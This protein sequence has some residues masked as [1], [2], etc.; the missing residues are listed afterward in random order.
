MV[1]LAKAGSRVI[2]VVTA[3]IVALLILYGGYSIWDTYSMSRNAFISNDLLRFKP[4]PGDIPANESLGDLMQI[5][6]DV[7]GW[8]TIDDTHIDYP[9][10]QGKDDME[11]VNKDVYGEYSLSGSIFLSSMNSPDFSDTYNVVFGHHMDNGAMFGDIYNFMSED[12]F[13]SHK[14][15][16]LY[17]RGATYHISV[18]ALLDTD[19]YDMIYNIEGINDSG[20]SELI[21]HLSEKSICYRDIGL[22]STDKILAMSTCY[23][24]TTS[25]RTILFGRLE[26]IGFS[27]HGVK[28]NEAT[29]E[30]KEVQPR[31]KSGVD[32]KI[33]T[34]V[35]A[36][37][38]LGVLVLIL[39]LHI[40]R[41]IHDRGE[42]ES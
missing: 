32:W 35:F 36:C 31:V 42:E 38:L 16:T 15:G 22:K 30:Y 24:A 37:I 21:D 12:Y 39:V 11:Y 23:D 10:V 5:N 4:Q 28:I 29:A 13:G 18:F 20:T 9:V 3:I 6:P 1:I 33:I 2:G 34:R 27:E 19:A 17:L 25:G 41:K 40:W 8:L 26:P 7:R 14:T